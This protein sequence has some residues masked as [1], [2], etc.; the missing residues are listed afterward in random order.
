MAMTPADPS[1]NGPARPAIVLAVAVLMFAA[2]AASMY[3]W[4]QPRAARMASVPATTLAAPSPVP[5]ATPAPPSPSPVESAPSPEV[6]PSL[7]PSAEPAP[8]AGAPRPAR[9][10]PRAGA[11]APPVQVAAAAPGGAPEPAG[12][13]RPGTPA[14]VPPRFVLG[15]TDVESLK[16]LGRGLRGFE[17]EGV[18]VKRAPTVDGQLELVMEPPPAGGGQPYAVRVY[19]R[20]AGRKPIKIDGMN[21]SMVV[22]GQRST[23]PIPPKVKE[24]KAQ[25]RTLLDELPGIWKDGA[26]TWMVEVAVTSKSQDVYRNRLS[27]Q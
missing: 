25:E 2:G 22:D 5:T 12:V 17:T 9:P 3:F 8:V 7:V 13:P 27:W 26:K 6:P 21:V 1:P 10:R 18:G 24:V 23:R 14:W 19:L 20:N 15:S 11:V 4:M 16:P